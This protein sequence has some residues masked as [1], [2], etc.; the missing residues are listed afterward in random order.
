MRRMMGLVLI[1][2][3][4]GYALTGVVQVPPGERA[5]VRRFGRILAE[6][7]EPGLWIGFPWGIDEVTLIP[8]DRV[9]D[10]T[11]GFN[12]ETDV[13]QVPPGQMLTGDHN[14]VNIQATL[15]YKVRSDQLEDYFVNRGQVREML[16]RAAEAVLA[17][18]IG[19]RGVDDV[20]L[21]GKVTL[22]PVL[23]TSLGD[24]LSSY[25]IGILVLD[26]RVTV[27]APP[28][29]VKMAFDQVGRTESGIA[30][31]IN[32]ADQ[33]AESSL[34]NAQAEQYRLQQNTAAAVHT[35]LELARS[36]AQAFRQRLAEYQRARVS[37]PAYLRQIWDE[38]RG[39]LFAKLKENGQIGLLDHHLG[40]NGLDM[41][42][43][44]L[45]PKK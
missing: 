18:W 45:P 4:V 19:S 39:R 28:D 9:Q 27:I 10:V 23:L 13:D 37:N 25:R 21:N 12:Q 32:K 31:L 16:G 40:P 1:L 17:E 38:E 36:E 6:N 8:V 43:A 3:M 20:L 34:R 41:T 24:R 2:G 11:I 42:I 14:L 29:D 35:L 7:P 5:V 15:T 26:A 33:E 22:R 44:P 30:T